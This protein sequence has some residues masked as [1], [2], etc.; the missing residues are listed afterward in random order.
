[1]DILQKSG[2]KKKLPNLIQSQT[3]QDPPDSNLVKTGGVQFQTLQIPDPNFSTFR[4]DTD[5]AGQHTGGVI[6]PETG[7]PIPTAALGT[8]LT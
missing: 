8:Y 1:M 4:H 7:A 3:L 6:D 2:Y 5:G